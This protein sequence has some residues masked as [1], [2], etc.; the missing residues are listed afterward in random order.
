M[1]ISSFFNHHIE[2]SDIYSVDLDELFGHILRSGALTPKDRLRLKKALLQ[3]SLPED[4]LLIINRLLYGV[5]RGFL[6][7]VG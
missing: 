4:H 7:L 5:R 1:Q 2:E 3:D 6:K